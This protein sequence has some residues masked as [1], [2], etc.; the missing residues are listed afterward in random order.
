M[1]D[2]TLRGTK[3]S[4]LTH[5]E[6]D[7]NFTNLKTA[8]EAGGVSVYAT[9]DDLPMS[10]NSNG[11]LALV[12][13]TNRLYIFTN[14]GWYNIALVNQTPTISG[15]EASYELAT[16][17]T[18]TVVTLTGAD[19]EGI[20]ITWSAT[21]SGDTSAASVTNV[22]N[23]F[24]ITPST[25]ENDAGTLTVAFR[26]FD[27]VNIGTATS[28]FSLT[29]SFPVSLE[30]AAYSGQFFTV[31]SNPVG[32]QLKPDG[33]KFY[34]EKAQLKTLIEYSLSTA[35]NPATAT[36]SYSL[37]MGPRGS[38]VFDST[39]QILL[40]GTN[41]NTIAKYT[42]ST[43]WDLSTATATGDTFQ[44]ATAYKWSLAASEDGTKL[45]YS[46][47]ISADGYYEY[48]MSTAWDITT[49]SFVAFHDFSAETGGQPRGLKFFEAGS[50]LIIAD[51]TNNRLIEYSLST[52]YDLSTRTQLRTFSIASQEANIDNFDVS[53]EYAVLFLV[54]TNSDRIHK[55]TL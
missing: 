19:P 32:A 52:N 46:D 20:P 54:G 30:N 5:D 15:N 4:P 39:G 10:G 49:L 36:Q 29:F 45:W 55:Y 28:S 9:I 48:S 11:D 27:G 2:V 16:D 1:V 6:V 34:V 31:G 53:P 50:K 38:F 26:A 44:F 21:T 13:S 23:V 14:S 41:D 40:L 8:V 43:A 51:N 17:G 25:D 35:F 24:T 33:T 3:G 18:P 47:Y 42:L 12:S 37:S 7:A 22:D